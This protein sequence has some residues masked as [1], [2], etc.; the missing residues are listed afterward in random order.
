MANTEVFSGPVHKPGTSGYE[1][2]RAGFNLAVEHRPESIVE[3]TGVDDVVAAVRWAV[4]GG[5]PVA[6]MNTGHG[7]TVPTDG[8]VMINTGRLKGVEVDPARRAARFG[9]GVRW[10][11]VIRAAAPHGLAPLNG[12][13]PDVGAVGYT[14]GGGVGLLGRRYGFAADHVRAITVVTA[15]ATVRRATADTDPD[16]FWALRGA[17]ANFGVVTEM[18][19]D[20]FPVARLLGGGLYFGPEDCEAVLSRYCDWSAEVP[21]EMASSVLLLTYPDDET[22]PEPLRGRHITEVRFAYSG[23]DLA[24]GRHWIEEFRRVGRPVLDTVDVLPYADMGTIHHEPTGIPVAAYDKN[25]LLGPLDSHAAAALYK[26]AGPQAQAPFPTE[27]RAFGGALARPPAVPN[28]VGARDASFSL[29]A[30]T[31]DLADNP[32]RDA[33]FDAMRPWGTGMG[34]LNFM[35]VEDARRDGVRTAYGPEDLARLTE[36][37]A[38]Y[39]PDNTFRINHNIPSKAPELS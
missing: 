12:S 25:T 10:R 39:D 8:S 9:A 29:F 16:L 1:N 4:A 36:L 32:A 5:R 3:T 24:Q 20:L 37:K 34:Y 21:E 23:T 14:L 19:I 35:G 31:V 33:L 18:E 2:G 26:Q 17:G 15:D 38:M 27:L 22:V 13:S 30:A 28:C 6:V 7:P 11:D